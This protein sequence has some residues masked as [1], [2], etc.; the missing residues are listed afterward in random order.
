M[1]A[2]LR[3]NALDALTH[4]HVAIV[5]FQWLLSCVSSGGAPTPAGTSI[6]IM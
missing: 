4:R 1:A 5:S 2:I 6:F 3:V